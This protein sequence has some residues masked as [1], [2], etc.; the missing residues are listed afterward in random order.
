LSSFFCVLSAALDL[1]I[2]KEIGNCFDRALRQE[3][4]SISIGT[5]VPEFAQQISGTSP[6]RRGIP[7]GIVMTFPRRKTRYRTT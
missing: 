4:E 3:V 6:G 2:G 5:V 7:A 1:S